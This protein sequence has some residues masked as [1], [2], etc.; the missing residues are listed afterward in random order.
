MGIAGQG[1]GGE[2][3]DAGLVLLAGFAEYHLSQDRASIVRHALI[4]L[5]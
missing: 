2:K 5:A 1:R 4:F 3:Q